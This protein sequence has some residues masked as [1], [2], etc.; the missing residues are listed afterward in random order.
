MGAGVLGVGR[1]NRI[2]TWV[3]KNTGRRRGPG[4]L[5]E[6]VGHPPAPVALRFRQSP[7]SAG[8]IPLLDPALTPSSECRRARAEIW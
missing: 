2:L 8:S 4:I 5:T 7:V 6:G 3:G 1:A